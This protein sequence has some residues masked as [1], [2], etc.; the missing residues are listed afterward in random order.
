MTEWD[1][2]LGLADNAVPPTEADEVLVVTSAIEPDA[3]VG[4][5]QDWFGDDE[6]RTGL[7]LLLDGTDR[8]VLHRTGAYDLVEVFDRGT[9]GAGGHATLPG[10]S[11]EYVLLS[12]H[13]PEP[14]CQVHATA[15]SYDPDD[16]PRCAVHQVDLRLDA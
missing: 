14:G 3:V 10:H 9:L 7:R 8:G 6:G 12:F 4:Y 15:L 1:E 13:C 5:L 11:V 2:V 16:P